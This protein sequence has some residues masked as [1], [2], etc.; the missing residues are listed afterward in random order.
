LSFTST[1]VPVATGTAGVVPGNGPTEGA[2]TPVP[3]GMNGEVTGPDG[4][5]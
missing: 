2:W 1:R 5:P 3:T 4:T